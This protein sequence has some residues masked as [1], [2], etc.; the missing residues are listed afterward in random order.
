LSDPQPAGGTYDVTGAEALTL[1]Q[2][3]ERLAAIAGRQLRYEEETLEEGRVWRSQLDAAAWE[4]DAWLG[5]YEAIAAGELARVSDTVE[6]FTGS[7]PMSL[8]QFFSQTPRA[9][10]RLKSRIK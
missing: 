4:V 9:L 7:A 6:R 1:A 10:E 3:A 8:E 2:T 5:S